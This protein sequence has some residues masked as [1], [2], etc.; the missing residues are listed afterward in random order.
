M[1]SLKQKTV[2]GF[3][4]LAINNIL[5]KVISIGT[6][7]I[8]A[9]LLEPSVFGLFAMAFI[10]IDGLSMFKT[11]GLDGSLVQ[12][13]NAPEVANDTAFFLIE[14]MSVTLFL[15][16]FIFAP[17]IARFF[18]NQELGSIVRALG[19]VFV[20]GGLAR[21]PSALLTKK[22]RFKLISF[23]DLTGSTVNCIFAVI[24]AL[25]SPTVWSL[26]GAYVIKQT[27]MT[28][29]AWS[30]SGYK[31][32]WRF[33]FGHARELFNFGKYLMLLSVVSYIGSNINNVVI[34]KLLGVAAVGYYTLAS[35]IGNLINTHFTHVISRVMFPA[36]S[37]MQDDRETLKRAYLKTIKF[38]SMFAF[39]FSIALICLSKE[40]VLT[41]YGAKWISIIP[42][43]R[44]LGFAQM[45]APIMIACGSLYR[46]C[47][48][49]AYDFRMNLGYLCFQIPTMII[50]TKH[51]GVTGTVIAGIISAMV[52]TPISVYLV[53][54]IVAFKISEFFAQLLPAASCAL[55]MLVTI[56]LSKRFLIVPT[57]FSSVAFHNL[58]LL[59][60]F[61]F[62]GVLSY[63]SAFFFVDR[64]AS[65]EVKRM[66][67]NLDGA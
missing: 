47:G 9:R 2:S 52:F 64:R 54:R 11:F 22:M 38:I 21:V 63:A 34:G 36:Y 65:L 20:L 55:V 7:A 51:W 39:P 59:A 33:D 35:N 31:L 43:I 48:K 40:F 49:P 13:K 18:G 24:F 4:W 16:C 30:F 62:V 53:R 58:I 23:I 19:I 25:I 67:F 32:R 27:I 57:Y 26:V 44:L 29:L 46:G 42:L 45:V 14:G 8:L 6:F 5:Q 41:L 1:A 37:A 28:L 3:K 56:F 50:L 15:I 61:S 66:I 12:K 17:L 10:A 60:L